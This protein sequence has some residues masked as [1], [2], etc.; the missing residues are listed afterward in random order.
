[1][2]KLGPLRGNV[3]T[4]VIVTPS[5]WILDL[6]ARARPVAEAAL[7][8]GRQALRW[9]SGRTG[10][11]MVVVAALTLVVAWRV[12]RRTWQIALELALAVAALLAAARLGWIRW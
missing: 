5:P 9:T 4:W 7:A 1:V 6:E 2:G 8:S 10:L 12:A 3:A 11:P